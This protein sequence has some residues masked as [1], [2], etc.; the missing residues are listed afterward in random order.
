[1]DLCALAAPTYD[2]EPLGSCTANGI[3][4][5]LIYTQKKEGLVPILFPSRLFIYYNERKREGT[6]GED[7]GAQIRTGIKSVAK[8]GFCTEEEWPYDI[9]KFTEK[10]PRGDYIEARK[11]LIKQYR[12][13]DNTDLQSLK[14]CLAEGFPFVFGF[15]V[16]ESFEFPAVAKTGRASMPTEG[17]RPVGGHAVLAMGYNQRTKR[18]LVQNSWGTGWGRKGFFTIPFDYLINPELAGDFWTIRLI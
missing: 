11:H 10:P 16:F 14:S 12:R 15:T 18:F 1:V 9:S 17:D 6:I 7:S 5:H 2:Q 4:A 8:E 3:G 13:L